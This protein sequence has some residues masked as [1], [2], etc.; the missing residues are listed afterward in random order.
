MNNYLIK[1]SS[2]TLI[3]K[4]IDE[5]IKKHGFIDAEVNIYDLDTWI[6]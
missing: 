1:S 5:L 4:K 2:K 6:Y 3:D